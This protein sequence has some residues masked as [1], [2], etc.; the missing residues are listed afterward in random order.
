VSDLGE[1]W[2]IVGEGMRLAVGVTL[3]ME[4][5]GEK[6]LEVHTFSRD[7]RTFRGGSAG[8]TSEVEVACEVLLVALSGI[9]H[10]NIMNT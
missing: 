3:P 4:V 5:L 2:S 9:F 8:R 10:L 7:G 1:E 6:G